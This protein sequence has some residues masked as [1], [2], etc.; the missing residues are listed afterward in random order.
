M[1][2]G[3]PIVLCVAGFGLVGCGSTKP[4]PTTSRGQARLAAALALADAEER[5]QALAKVA[6]QAAVEGEVDVVKAALGKVT[7]GPTLDA[8]AAATALALLEAGLPAPA[9]EVARLIRDE[10][11]RAEVLA[12]LAKG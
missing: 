8:A 11:L 12:T 5:D 3:M 2:R 7:A 4:G 9:N 10:S 1:R 6:Q